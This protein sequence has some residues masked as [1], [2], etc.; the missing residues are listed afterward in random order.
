MP[1][2]A[3]PEN[4]VGLTL[5]FRAL[6]LALVASAMLAG[7]AVAGLGPNPADDRRLIDRPIEN[8]RYDRATRCDKSAPPGTKALTDWLGRHTDGTFWGSYRCEKWS[9]GSYSVHSEGRA[10]DWAMD[11][12]DRSMK[13]QAMKL[14]RERLLAEDRR[15]NDNALAR[16][17]G[18]QGIIYDCHAW[19][20]GDGGLGP[21]SA[22]FNDNGKRIKGVDPTTAHVDHIH[23]E[24]NDAGARKKTSFWRSKIR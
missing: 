3:D 12:R 16:R 20:S 10:I 18:V 21:Y 9:K 17:M 22:C 15:G 24:L 5:T 8:Y 4:E 1:P 6:V 7:A 19:F 23:I 13:K 11:A 14:I 2:G